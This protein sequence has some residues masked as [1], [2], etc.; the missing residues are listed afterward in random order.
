MAGLVLWHGVWREPVSYKLSVVVLECELDWL[1]VWYF[2]LDALWSTLSKSRSWFFF[3]T[4]VDNFI[5]TFGGNRLPKIFEGKV[6]DWLKI[7]NL[8]NGKYKVIFQPNGCAERTCAAACFIYLGLGHRLD[9]IRLLKCT[10]VVFYW[11]VYLF[12]LLVSYFGMYSWIKRDFW[13][14]QY[15]RY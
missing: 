15:Y 6:P 8:F 5:V 13:I 2:V 10:L 12:I 14:K 3:L 7:K 4:F 1:G 9:N 11:F